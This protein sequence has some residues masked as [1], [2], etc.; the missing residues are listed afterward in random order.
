MHNIPSSEELDRLI[1]LIIELS[2]TNAS[3][4]ISEL[5]KPSKLP[6]EDINQMLKFETLLRNRGNVLM[7]FKITIL[8]RIGPLYIGLHIHCILV[9]HTVPVH[10]CSVG[11]LTSTHT[12]YSRHTLF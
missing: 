10:K 3:F 4:K 1:D 5:V 7:Y 8:A 2:P 9:K 6:T 12:L 11:T